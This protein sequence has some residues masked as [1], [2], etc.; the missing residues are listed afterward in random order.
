[1]HDH[2]CT[3]QTHRDA[4][5]NPIG[6]GPSSYSREVTTKRAAGGGTNRDRS[7]RKSSVL[8]P[9]SASAM[10]CGAGVFCTLGCA[11]TEPAPL[12]GLRG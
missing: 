11:S 2:L 8:S 4:R 12:G 9:L 1:M 7:P 5:V 10:V 6:S 3:A